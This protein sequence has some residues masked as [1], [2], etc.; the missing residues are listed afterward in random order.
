M[1]QNVVWPLD[2]E[3]HSLQQAKM[4]GSR[5]NSG[6]VWWGFSNR[7][8]QSTMSLANLVMAQA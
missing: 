3:L 2:A 6:S 1:V 5:S 4:V 7:K 8:E